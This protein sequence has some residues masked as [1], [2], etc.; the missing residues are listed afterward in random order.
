MELLW[1]PE[2]RKP[3][4]EDHDIKSLKILQGDLGTLILSP[5]L[6]GKMK[7]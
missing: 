3:P 5:S 7:M 1:S 6:K 2:K 4:S